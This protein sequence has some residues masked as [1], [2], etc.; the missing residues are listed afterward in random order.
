M[1]TMR[2][3]LTKNDHLERQLNELRDVLAEVVKER[4]TTNLYN[5]LRFMPITNM[6]VDVFGRREG[7]GASAERITSLSRFRN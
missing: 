4:E 7:D 5:L 3:I 2:D 6:F 1:K